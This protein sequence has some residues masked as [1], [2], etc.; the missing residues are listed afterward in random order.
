L[1][2]AIRATPVDR[3]GRER[4]EAA[5]KELPLGVQSVVFED[6][7]SVNLELSPAASPK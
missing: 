4:A 2:I 6:P 1:L 5:L 7:A 3:A